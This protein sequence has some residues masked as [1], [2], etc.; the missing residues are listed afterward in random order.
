[1]AADTTV[2]RMSVIDPAVIRHC[3]KHPARGYAWTLRE[4]ARSLGCSTGTLSLISTGGRL[5]LPTWLAV[6][7]AEAV[8][9]ETETL[10]VPVLAKK[11]ATIPEQGAHQ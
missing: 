8:G 11:S 10:F 5:T 6:R 9:V 2:K 4:L 1:M 3:I 7:F